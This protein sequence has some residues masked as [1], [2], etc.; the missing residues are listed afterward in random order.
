LCWPTSTSDAVPL[1]TNCAERGRGSYTDGRQRSEPGGG[2][3]AAASIDS[4]AC[5]CVQQRRDR[6]LVRRR[7]G[8]ETWRASWRGFGRCFLRM[9]SA[10]PRLRR[11]RRAIVNTASISGLFGDYGLLGTT[12]K[13]GG[14]PDAYHRD[15]PCPGG[16]PGQRRLSGGIETPLLAPVLGYPGRA[17]NTPNWCRW[18][19]SA[20]EEVASVVAFLASERHRTS[21]GAHCGRWA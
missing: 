5:T 17:R 10:I 18:G 7:T 3:D 11:R 19:G 13:G 1:W 16:Y 8:L 20:A 9:S 4:A 21:Q 12:R 14:Q 2:V 6:A 15:R